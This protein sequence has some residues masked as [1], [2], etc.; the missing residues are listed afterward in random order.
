[1][2]AFER[3][4]RYVKVSDHHLLARSRAY[5]MEILVDGILRETVAYGE[6]P[7][8]AIPG[9]DRPGLTRPRRHPPGMDGD[10]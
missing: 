10:D 1:M 7:D 2:M 6:N 9:L 5:L 3:T 8:H 4:A